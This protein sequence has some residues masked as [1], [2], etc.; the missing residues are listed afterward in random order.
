MS[1]Q[2]RDAQLTIL[3]ESILG[4]PKEQFNDDTSTDNTAG[5]ESVAHLNLI[6]AIEETFGISFMPEDTMEMTSV[7]LIK[8]VL[9][10]KLGS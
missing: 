7:R 3:F 4:L 6:M 9:D 8:L 5:W 10:E 2:D 1:T